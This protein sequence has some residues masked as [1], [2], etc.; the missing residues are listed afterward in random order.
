MKIKNKKI[1]F[2]TISFLALVLILFLL[3]NKNVKNDAYLDS[4]PEDQKEKRI[5]NYSRINFFLSTSNKASLA[6]P[7]YWEGNYRVREQGETAIFYFVEGV[8]SEV[9]L[10]SISYKQK[11]S[12][13]AE[14]NQQIIGEK[15]GLDFILIKAEIQDL[16]SKMYQ[17]MFSDIGG[18]V[19][20]FKVS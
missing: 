5:V 10:F 1:I 7:D 15:G 9:E 8:E 14:K 11:D 20:S 13:E 4:G 6:M 19:K 18:L 12:Y 16:S 2:A 17:E 3:Q